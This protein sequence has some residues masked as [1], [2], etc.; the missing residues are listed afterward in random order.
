M[1]KSFI[2]PVMEYACVV[3]DGCSEKNSDRLESVQL[4]AGRIVC[5]AIKHT[6]HSIIYNELGWERLSK[7]RERFKLLLFHKMVHGIAP[8]YLQDMLPQT[9]AE[10]NSYQVRNASGLS[11]S[12]VRTR[13]SLFEHSFLPSSIKLWNMLPEEQRT[14]ADPQTFKKSLLPDKNDKV[15]LFFLGERRTNITHSRL[16]M[17]CSALKAHLYDMH[18]IDDPRCT[19]GAQIEDSLF[20]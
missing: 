7:R 10:R 2:R 18:I 13:L 16:R 20:V 5:G 3:W 11:Q 9:V 4:R 15:N 1:Y 8:K 6:S 14:I 12:I 19:C 17:N